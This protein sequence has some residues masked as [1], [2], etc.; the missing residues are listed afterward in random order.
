[1]SVFYVS[2]RVGMLLKD[3]FKSSFDLQ[4]FGSETTLQ[5]VIS[6]PK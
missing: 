4:N 6:V 1:M 3:V 5:L 2:S